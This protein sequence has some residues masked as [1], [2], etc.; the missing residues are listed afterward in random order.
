MSESIS[1]AQTQSQSTS[2]VKGIGNIANVTTSG[3]SNFAVDL[4]AR[5]PADISPENGSAN[6]SAS[7]SLSTNSSVSVNNTQF[8]SAFIQAFAPE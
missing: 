3:D 6:G 7:A 5:A 8:S 4:A 1:A 2:E